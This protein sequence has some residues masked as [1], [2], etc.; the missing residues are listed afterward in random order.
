MH[1]ICDRLDHQNIEYNI[2][3]NKNIEKTRRINRY[4]LSFLFLMD[5]PHLH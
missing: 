1:D 2:H 5:K 4:I 3:H